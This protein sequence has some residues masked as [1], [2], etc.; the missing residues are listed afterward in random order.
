MN[1]VELPP[2]VRLTQ[3]KGGGPSWPTP[4]ATDASRGGERNGIPAHV[5]ASPTPVAGHN[6]SLQHAVRLWPTP[7]ASCGTGPG[8]QGRDGGPNLQ[9]AVGGLLNPVWVEWLMGFP[10]GWTE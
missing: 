2:L 6:V 1:G 3:R 5:L 4:T 8:S 7:H 9:T 10:V